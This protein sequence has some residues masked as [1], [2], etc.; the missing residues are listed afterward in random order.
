MTVSLRHPYGSRRGPTENLSPCCIWY[1]ILQQLRCETVT[2]VVEAKSRQPAALQ[3]L[4]QAVRQFAIGRSRRIFPFS[5]DGNTKACGIRL[6]NR[7]A[8]VSSAAKAGPFGGTLRMKQDAS[9]RA[10]RVP[11][12]PISSTAED[13]PRGQSLRARTFVIEISPDALDWGFVTECQKAADS[14]AYAQALSGFVR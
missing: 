3:I 6:E 9:L 13:V 7:A 4:R 5:Q 8:Q 2:Q 1:R 10:S 14:G 12:G 11:R